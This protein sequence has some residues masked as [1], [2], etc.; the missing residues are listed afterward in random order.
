MS[1]QFPGLLP[2]AVEVE[3]YG[4]EPNSIHLSDRRFWLKGAAVTWISCR[5]DRESNRV[6]LA[7]LGGSLVVG[8]ARAAEPREKPVLRAAFLIGHDERDVTP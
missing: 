5:P 2:T 6:V 7:G 8:E 1:T 4:I 3:I